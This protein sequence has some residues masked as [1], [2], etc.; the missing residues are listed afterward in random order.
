MHKKISLIY[1]KI[2]IKLG[3]QKIGKKYRKLIRNKKIIIKNN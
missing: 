3:M 1:K 2:F